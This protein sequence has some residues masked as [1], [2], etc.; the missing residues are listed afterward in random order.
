MSR[1]SAVQL[2]LVAPSWPVAPARTGCSPKQRE[3]A[4]QQA[5]SD[6]LDFDGPDDPY[7]LAGWAYVAPYLHVWRGKDG[8]PTVAKQLPSDAFFG[9]GK[10][11]QHAPLTP[12][13]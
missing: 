13:R 4:L 3:D 2:A 5:V 7:R 10:E 1:S 6:W 11:H 8:V 12:R 9:A